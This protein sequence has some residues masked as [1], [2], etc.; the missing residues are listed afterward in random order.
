MGDC[1]GRTAGRFAFPLSDLPP[2]ASAAAHAGPSPT[3]SEAT[4]R[5]GQRCPALFIDHPPGKNGLVNELPT[6]TDAIA[7]NPADGGRWLA[8]AAWFAAY[9]RD[10]EAVAVRVLW[11][12]FRDNLAYTTVA[13]TLDNLAANAPLFGKIAR[14]IEADRRPADW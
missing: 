8:L 10:D 2:G 11:P 7:L 3:T 1:A 6:I 14:Q 12:T 5:A 9:G 4:G 13:A